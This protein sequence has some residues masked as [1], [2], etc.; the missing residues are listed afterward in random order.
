MWVCVLAMR[1]LAR[2]GQ[3][4]KPAVR[5]PVL[6]GP[7]HS[8]MQTSSRYSFGATFKRRVLRPSSTQPS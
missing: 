7:T 3:W 5:L 2:L 4:Q 8:A 1:L 6:Y